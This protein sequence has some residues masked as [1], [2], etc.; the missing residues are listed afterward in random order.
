MALNCC[1]ARRHNGT[2]RQPDT[3][4]YSIYGIYVFLA[5]AQTYPAGLLNNS[6]SGAL[7]TLFLWKNSFK[8]STD[9]DV[10]HGKPEIC[11]MLVNQY[12]RLT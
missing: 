9:D 5:Y 1:T 8:L 2:C 10:P 6:W 7:S 11:C 3:R 12:A 4:I